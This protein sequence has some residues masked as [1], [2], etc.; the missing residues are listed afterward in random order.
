MLRSPTRLPDA[1]WVA[2]V[3]G[4]VVALASTPG[5]SKPAE[6]AP[7]PAAGTLGGPRA[8]LEA[9]T[10]A[11]F[12][13]GHR[14]FLKVYDEEMGL[15]PR[16][17]DVSCV[18]CHF[19]PVPGGGAGMDHRA[20]VVFEP[21]E[22]VEVWPI[23]ATPGFDPLVVPTTHTVTYRRP[24]SLL[25]LGLLEAIDDAVIRANCDPDD[26]D[27]D[28]VRGHAN[29]GHDGRVGRVGFKAHNSTIRDFVA[30]ALR[31]EIG[32]TN[33]AKRD[34]RFR[35]DRDK[36]PDPEVG[37]AV[38]DDLAAFVRGL[39]PPPRDGDHPAGA[40]VFADVGCATCHKPSPGPGADGAYTDLCVHDL[41]KHFDTGIPDFLAKSPEWRTAPLWGLRFRKAY[42]HDER[43]PDLEQ[44]ILLHGGEAQGARDRFAA[45]APPAKADLLRFLR[46][47]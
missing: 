11:A 34:P 20:R 6:V 15:G 43:T 27:G 17:N 4:V 41:G 24:P 22:F 1:A 31:A 45:L 30:S 36:V 42:L 7:V 13:R 14:E 46:T 16:Y 39:A 40:K 12:G 29:V 38:I 35:T 3:V 28:G 19:D 9:A 10:L 44:A 23:K 21:P 25:G 18:S 37:D 33:P 8:G 32:I 2:A 5:C 47:L 26:R